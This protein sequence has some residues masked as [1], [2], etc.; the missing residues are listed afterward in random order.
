MLAAIAKA[1]A[2]ADGAAAPTGGAG[3][4][5]ALPDP[6]VLHDRITAFVSQ[7]KVDDAHDYASEFAKLKIENDMVNTFFDEIHKMSDTFVFNYYYPKFSYVCWVVFHVFIHFFRAEY[8]LTYLISLLILA[9]VQ[10]SE[11][12]KKNMTPINNSLFF[13]DNMLHPSI[14]STNNI[15]TADN[16][17]VLKKIQA[18]QQ[19]QKKIQGG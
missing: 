1:S 13:R 2:A 5:D 19:S 6:E 16:I 3:S 10:H 18:L 15:L 14:L 9:V 17:T 11:W 12:W 8:L 4:S 7:P